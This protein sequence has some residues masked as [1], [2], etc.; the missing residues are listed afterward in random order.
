MMGIDGVPMPETIV[1][2]SAESADAA[3]STAAAEEDAEPTDTVV[4]DTEDA[5]QKHSEL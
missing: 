1:T 2:K 3:E 5:Q 4:A